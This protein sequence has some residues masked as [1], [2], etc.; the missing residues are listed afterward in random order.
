MNQKQRI[1]ALKAQALAISGGEMKSF[2]IDNLPPGLAEQFLQRVIA[3]ETA[4]IITDFAQ[5]TAEGVELP[6]PE[7]VP[8]SDIGRILWRVIAALST[9][10]VFLERTNHLSDRELYSV[11]WH[12]VLR[13]EHA[14]LPEGDTGAWHVDVPGDDAQATNYLMYYASERERD[15][16]RKDFPD[17]T[18][19]PHRD[20]AFD[21][22]AELPVPAP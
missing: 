22:D 17:A 18:V 2:G 4:P 20:P 3:F 21:R 14:A 9:H 15:L 5:L 8:D 6:E 12:D 13:E 7:T 19:P 10:Q 16:W 1:E 11:L